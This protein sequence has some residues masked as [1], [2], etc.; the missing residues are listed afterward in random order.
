MGKAAASGF[1]LDREG[2]GSI[3][4]YCGIWHTFLLFKVLDLLF[5]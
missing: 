3:Q 2:I 4:V 5:K 1:V